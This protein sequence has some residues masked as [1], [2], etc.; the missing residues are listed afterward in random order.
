MSTLFS[1][2]LVAADI[3]FVR[4]SKNT[5]IKRDSGSPKGNGGGGGNCTGT[6]PFFSHVGSLPSPGHF[7]T[8]RALPVS[9]GI[10]RGEALEH[11]TMNAQLYSPP[12]PRLPGYARAWFSI[13]EQGKGLLDPYLLLSYL[14]Q[15]MKADEL[16]HVLNC[17]PEQQP[18]PSPTQRPHKKQQHGEAQ[19]SHVPQPVPRKP[20]QTLTPPPQLDVSFKGNRRKSAGSSPIARAVAYVRG[21]GGGGGG[22]SNSGGGG[23]GSG[24]DST[25]RHKRKQQ[26]Q[27]VGDKEPM[28]SSTTRSVT[29]PPPLSATWSGTNAAQVRRLS[30]GISMGAPPEAATTLGLERASLPSPPPPPLLS[31]TP[32]LSATIEGYMP[33][34]I[35]IALLTD[36]DKGL[37]GRENT[38]RTPRRDANLVVGRAP[39]QR[40]EMGMGARPGPMT[41]TSVNKGQSS[42]RAEVAAAMSESETEAIVTAA[43]EAAAME[44]NLG[45]STS[46]TGTEAVG[47][48]EDEDKDDDPNV[49]EAV[50]VVASAAADSSDSRAEYSTPSA[51]DD[52]RNPAVYVAGSSEAREY[53]SNLE[54]VALDYADLTFYYSLRQHGR[55]NV[56]NPAARREVRRT[57]L[58]RECMTVGMLCDPT[59]QRTSST[60]CGLITRALK[61]LLVGTNYYM[62]I[63]AFQATEVFLTSLPLSYQ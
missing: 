45:S 50:S 19:H 4:T 11:Q 8:A 34:A 52:T 60:P 59:A 27:Q 18:R 39:G 7:A 44:T 63:H 53:D 25:V 56:D 20:G 6:P 26:Q 61:P 33:V 23:G 42:T 46:R 9:D 5:A 22:G 41:G 14:R 28:S 10:T 36:E 1:L 37:R 2:K 54:E 51:S 17:A 48:K 49:V 15:V 30:R 16:M 32:P 47:E 35:P 62:S 13:P 12:A 3:D 57:V 38:R 31:T 55:I 43:V 24:G 29:P 58:Q 40:P 21:G